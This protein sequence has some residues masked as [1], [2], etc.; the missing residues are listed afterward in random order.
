MVTHGCFAEIDRVG[1]TLKPGGSIFEACSTLA[2]DANA[3]DFLTSCHFIITTASLSFT[4]SLQ[5]KVPVKVNMTV[6]VDN[7]YSIGPD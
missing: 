1:G 6:T 4:Y 5:R 3:V 2:T 7:V